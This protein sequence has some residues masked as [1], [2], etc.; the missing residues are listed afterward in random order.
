MKKYTFLLITLVCSLFF[1]SSCKKKFQAFPYELRAYFPYVVNQEVS[2]VNDSGRILSGKVSQMNVSETE[3][4]PRTC[5][6]DINSTWMSVCIS[7]DSYSLLLSGFMN[8][9]DDKSFDIGCS[10]ILLDAVTTHS[11]G[12]HYDGDAFSGT[13]STILGDSLILEEGDE[14]VVIIKGKGFSELKFGNNVWRLKE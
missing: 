3:Y 9:N 6:C 8:T 11:V 2:F 4:S 14:K 7:S 12:K 1:L 10:Y 5:K 13:F